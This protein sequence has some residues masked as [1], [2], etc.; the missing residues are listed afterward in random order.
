LWLLLIVAVVGCPPPPDS[1]RDAALAAD[2][3]LPPPPDLSPRPAD[4]PLPAV[5]LAPSGGRDFH[6]SPAVVQV[7]SDHDILALGDIHGDY[8]R[9]VT[10]LVAARVVASPPT[11]PDSVDWAAGS[12][13]LV[14]TGDFIDK[15]NHALKVIPFLQALQL[16]ARKVGGDVIVTMGNHEAEFLADPMN[17][18][19][20][21]FIAELTAAGIS[22]VEVAAGKNSIGRFLRDLPIAARVRDWFFCHAGNS[23]GRTIANLASEIERQVTAMGFGAPILS[24]DNSILE[25]RLKPTPWF[26]GMG[27]PATTL[28]SYTSALGVAHIVMGH[29]PGKA[30]FADGTARASGELFQKFGLLFLVDVGMSQG[31]D[32]SQGALLRIV[33]VGAATKVTAYYPDATTK[34]FW[35]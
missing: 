7:D 5:D 17:S 2:A 29:Q 30:S 34:P 26:E 10:L 23:G 11:M 4:G 24:D 15:F 19:A 14:I 6:T 18:K 1:G 12:A 28:R 21:E 16:S 22:P 32:N 33:G 35:P 13:I 31:V 20:A 27:D 9:L 8:D 25:A 3:T